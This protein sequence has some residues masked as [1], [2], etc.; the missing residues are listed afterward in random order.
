MFFGNFTQWD[1]NQ[2]RLISNVWYSSWC[3]LRKSNSN[4]PNE[5]LLLLADFFLYHQMK[6]NFK[7][8]KSHICFRLSCSIDLSFIHFLADITSNSKI[9]YSFDKDFSDFPL[10][11]REHLE[12][13]SNVFARMWYVKPFLFVKMRG[14]WNNFHLWHDIKKFWQ[15]E[16]SPICSAE[17]IYVSIFFPLLNSLCTRV[18]DV[19]KSS[20]FIIHFWRA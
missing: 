20:S 16:N 2:S 13:V 15:S 1:E 12:L 4:I 19:D 5:S 17:Q 7:V 11:S 8:T 6:F 18:F 9:L 14:I 10:Y 3:M